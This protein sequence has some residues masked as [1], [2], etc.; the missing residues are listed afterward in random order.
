M[1]HMH[2][3][4]WVLAVI[5][6]IIAVAMLKKG[7]QKGYKITHMILRIDYL[8]ILA[9]GFDLMFRGNVIGEYYAKAVLGIIVIGL[10][11]MLLTRMNKN[12][13]AKGMGAAFVITVLL[14]IAFGFYLPQGMDFLGL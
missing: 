11:E 10:A 2:I 13:N 7:N 6:V 5:L 4:T 12:V 14:T 1:T 8:L 9:T 3:T